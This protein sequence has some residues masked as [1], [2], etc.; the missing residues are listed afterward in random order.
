MVELRYTIHGPVIHED[1]ARH[2]AYALRWVG[3]EPGTAGYLAALAVARA[4]NWNEFLAAMD[5]YKVPSENLV[6]ADVDGNIGWQAAGLAPI[7]P[8]WSGLFPVPGAEGEYE[9][10]GFRNMA[11]L[12][13]LYNPPEHFIATANHNILPPG[14]KI[15]LAYE[16]AA[17]FRYLR[18]REMLAAGRK[19]SVADFERMQQDVV[20]LP[21]RRFQ[22][23][24][25]KWDVP[26]RARAVV[27]MLLDWN[28]ALTADSTAALIYEVWINKLPAAFF[29][30]ETGARVT[31]ETLLDRLE[32]QI[33]GQPNCDAMA[34]SFDLAVAQLQRDFGP[35]RRL[36]TWGR[37]HQVEFRHPV[38]GIAG[39]GR[40]P[41]PGDATTVNAT[42]GPGLRQTAGASS[43]Q[44]L[45]L[46]DWDQSVMTNVP[47]ESGNPSSP[48]YADLAAGWAAG[49]YHPLP[50]SRAAVEKACEERIQLLPPR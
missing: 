12:P 49:K 33:D 8:N 19:F 15:P 42:S 45:D 2:R 23:V 43:R 14:Y 6:Y 10:T 9:W 30:P 27:G 36:W 5:H 41:R 37:A 22:A 20:S 34:V 32:A 4:R 44:I 11:E 39:A 48:H 17:P 40:F 3:T 24:L 25:A 29:G 35:D 46:S 47:G 7:R 16:W 1:R 13:R 28:A 38:P 21:A 18:I 26:E 31:L 50:F